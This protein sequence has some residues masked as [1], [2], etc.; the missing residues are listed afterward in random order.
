MVNSQ[1]ATAAIP[2]AGKDKESF[3]PSSS[4]CAGIQRITLVNTHDLIGG[5][6]RCSYDL[7][8]A[9]RRRGYQPYLIVGGKYGTDDDV[10]KIPFKEYEWKTAKFLRKHVGL[11]EVWHPTPFL[12]CF[13]WPMLRDAEIVNIHNMHGQ[14]W[15]LLTLLPL[16][17]TRPVVLTLHDEYNLTG[18]CCYTYDCNRWKRSCGQCPRAEVHGPARYAIGERDL[19]RI[20]VWI[21]RLIF[22]A[23]KRFPIV[24]VSPS[25]WLAKQTRESP[26]LRHLPV[27]CIP[28]GVD[29]DFWKPIDQTEARHRWNLP[30]DARIGLLTAVNLNDPRKGSDVALAAIRALPPHSRLRFILAGKLDNQISKLIEGLP[31]VSV[32]HI[33]DKRQMVE[34]YSA[35]DFT[36]VLSRADNLPY[37]CLESLACGRPVFGSAVG[38]IPEV[39]SGPNL[40]WLTPY[41]LQVEAITKTL[42]EIAALSQPRL[43]EQ[44][45]TCR[46]SAATVFSIERMVNSYVAL[47]QRLHEQGRARK[48][49]AG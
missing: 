15:N 41:P 18:D 11:T 43:L 34:L 4:K 16:A 45:L 49:L 2:E 37:T 17:H 24:L 33:T 9:L 35:A 42:L 6:E 12:G 48:T 21:K 25:E 47:F 1:S 28:N 5:A 23:P 19:T 36:V 40:G 31:I 44:F 38:G 46:Q 13:R 3:R 10:F 7:H 22:R 39:I 8:T 27:Q 32:G 30:V 26:N 14:F 20:N 29:L